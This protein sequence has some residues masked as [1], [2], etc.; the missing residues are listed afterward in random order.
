[1][2]GVNENIDWL[3][4]PNWEYHFFE[5]VKNCVVKKTLLTYN[6]LWKF[7]T[8]NYTNISRNRF[9]KGQS[10]RTVIYLNGRLLV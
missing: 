5:T 10:W 1:V 7:S 4:C 9:L 6:S 2:G 8:K 3:L